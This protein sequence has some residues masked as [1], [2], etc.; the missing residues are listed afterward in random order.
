MRAQKLTLQKVEGELR[1]GF[2]AYLLGGTIST[3]MY[4]KQANYRAELLLEKYAEPLSTLAW[5]MGGGDYPQAELREAWRLLLSNLPHDSI[6][7]CG[8]DP[9]HDEMMQRYGFLE[10]LGG[11]IVETAASAIRTLRASEATPAVGGTGP[12]APGMGLSPCSTRFSMRAQTWC[13]RAS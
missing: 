11:S 5:I 3:R 4:L 12:T 2:R 1:S 7:G 13:G 10:D 6:C 8:I 9:I